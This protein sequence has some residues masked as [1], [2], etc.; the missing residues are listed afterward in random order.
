M[1]NLGEETLPSKKYV[2]AL[3]K[4]LTVMKVKLSVKTFPH[5][6][7]GFQLIGAFREHVED[8][9]SPDFLVNMKSMQIVGMTRSF[10]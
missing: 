4:N 7:K 3:R 1:E 10:S 5:L 8:R 6:E 9:H 2:Y